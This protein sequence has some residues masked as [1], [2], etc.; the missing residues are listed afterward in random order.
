MHIAADFYETL[1]D[2]IISGSD[3]AHGRE[4]LYILESGEYESRQLYHAV[5][6]SLFEAGKIDSDK[7]VPLT[8]AELEKD[9]LVSLIVRHTFYC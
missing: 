6:K 7:P 1:F 2:A 3:P 5:G 8:A 4:G 9:F